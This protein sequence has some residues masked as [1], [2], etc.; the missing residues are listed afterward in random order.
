VDR[1]GWHLQT[2][3]FQATTPIRNS[4]STRPTNFTNLVFTKNP[5]AP[6]RLV[7]AAHY[8]S[9][10]WVDGQQFDGQFIGA[11]DSAWPCAL[12]AELARAVDP[13]LKEDDEATLQVIFFDGE[14]A[15]VHWG[16]KDSL[17][18]STHL[19]Q[20]WKA[21]PTGKSVDGVDLFIL[22]DL[23]G[24]AKPTFRLFPKTIRSHYQKLAAIEK[25]LRASSML[26]TASS[27]SFFSQHMARDYVEDDHL[28]FERLGIPVVHLIP[29]PFP[30]VWHTVRDDESALDNATITD[31]TLIFYHFLLDYFNAKEEQQH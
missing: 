7:L 27:V 8:D 12:L 6:R 1:L 3:S 21:D 23:L 17:Y 29:T 24:A 10:P 28:P 30:A 22:F 26:S 11:T 9:K 2:D 5:D 16:P 14:E 15:H 20:A 13:L 25:S 31:L 19:A 4:L 18:G